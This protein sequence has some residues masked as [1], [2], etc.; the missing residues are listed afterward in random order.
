MKHPLASA[1]LLGI[2]VAA[3][4]CGSSKKSSKEE[5]PTAPTAPAAPAAAG[6][7]PA[8]A[9]A[10]PAAPAP[11]RLVPG[12]YACGFSNS[13]EFLCRITQDGEFVTL[14][15]LGGSERFS[16]SLSAGDNEGELAWTNA[17]AD[18]APAG[19]TF[20][21]QPDGSWFGEVPSDGEKLGYRLRYLGELGSQFGG[22]SY[23]GAIGAAPGL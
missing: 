19:L 22:K 3:S 13:A 16:G 2:L 9:P 8:A 20:K 10:A 14:E 1:L 5:A 21:R 6:D 4:A 15:K 18:G 7:R 23:G 11:E 17:K 12:D